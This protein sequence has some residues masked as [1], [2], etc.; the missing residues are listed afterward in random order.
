MAS[1]DWFKR[2]PGIGKVILPDPNA[3]TGQEYPDGDPDHKRCVLCGHWN[4][5]RSSACA[6]CNSRQWQGE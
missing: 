3:R 6:F 2:T 4:L 1:T 5:T